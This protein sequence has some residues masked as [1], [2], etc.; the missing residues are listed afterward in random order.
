MKNKLALHVSHLLL[1]FM[2]GCRVFAV[3]LLCQYRRPSFRLRIR[4]FKV[5]TDIEVRRIFH[6]TVSPHILFVVQMPG[7]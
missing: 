7:A 5:D 4:Q 3:T 1:T 2:T 6:R